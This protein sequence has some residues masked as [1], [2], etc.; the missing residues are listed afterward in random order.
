M[1][2]L[3]CIAFALASAH[4][5][6][7][8]TADP[9]LFS[10]TVEQLEWRVDDS[11]DPVVLEGHAWWGYDLQK[12][13]LDLDAEYADG[14]LEELELHA[15]YSRALSPYWDWQAGAR[16]DHQPDL[17]RTWAALGMHGL[18]PYFFESEA[19][20]FIG[21]DGA[22]ALRL[23]AEYEI[24]LTQQWILSPE[25]SL[26]FYGQNDAE[27]A[28]GS[29]LADSA[30]GWRLRYEIRPE[31]APYLGVEWHRSYGKTAD[32]VQALGQ[33]DSSQQWVLGVRF[34]F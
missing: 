32:F 20:L 27:T 16:Y 23:K 11:E 24:L 29:G 26:N 8:E 2:M 28:T 25:L 21:E 9:L 31:L 6:A 30:F 22:S 12:L 17:D 10:A 3:A 14:E 7:H 15:L 34:W 18:A 4:A 19:Y 5:A 13:W 33:A 1:K